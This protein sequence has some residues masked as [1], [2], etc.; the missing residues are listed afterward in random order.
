MCIRDRLVPL[1]SW[2]WA[3]RASVKPSGSGRAPYSQSE[4]ARHRLLPTQRISDLGRLI[5]RARAVIA[6]Q[7]DQI[8][9]S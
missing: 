1:L 9:P 7:W 6:Y 2:P 4:A 5:I 8:S 3:K